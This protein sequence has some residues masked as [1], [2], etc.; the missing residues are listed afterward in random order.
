MKVCHHDKPSGC[1]ASASVYW[2]TVMIVARVHEELGLTYVT[3]RNVYPRVDASK[4]KVKYAMD[5]MG[6]EGLLKPWNPDALANRTYRIIPD[7]IDSV[8]PPG[9]VD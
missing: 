1:P 7:R 5:A 3:P 6:K 2:Q 8:S 4:T 9:G